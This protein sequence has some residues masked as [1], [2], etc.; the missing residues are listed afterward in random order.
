[1]QVESVPDFSPEDAFK[2]S[3]TFALLGVAVDRTETLND[4]LGE[5]LILVVEDVEGDLVGDEVVALVV[6][7]RT[8]EES[9]QKDRRRLRD[10][11]EKL[12]LYYLVVV[13]VTASVLLLVDQEQQ[14]KDLTSEFFVR[15]NNILSDG[16]RVAQ[17]F[18]YIL[19]LFNGLAYLIEPPG[20]QG[21][22]NGLI[23]LIVLVA[24][25]KHPSD[26]TLHLSINVNTVLFPVDHGDPLLDVLVNAL[27]DECLDVLTLL[28]QVES[29]SRLQRQPQ[30]ILVLLQVVEHLRGKGGCQFLLGEARLVQVGLTKH[31]VNRCLTSSRR[32]SRSRATRSPLSGLVFSTRRS[33]HH[34]KGPAVGPGSPRLKYVV[35]SQ[36]TAYFLV[37]S[38]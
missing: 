21:D 6:V 35:N 17:L 9:A 15:F 37:K 26:D 12:T 36:R 30:S 22:A 34:A 23:E 28:V 19:R 14:A 24:P 13:E 4:L 1:L 2:L 33:A 29:V 3:E 27:V 18:F 25:V 38:I 31:R 11:Q 5:T 20:L 7:T 8:L 32:S 10:V 16:E